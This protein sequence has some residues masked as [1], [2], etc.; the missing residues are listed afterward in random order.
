MI[1]YYN[2]HIGNIFKL[3]SLIFMGRESFNA[4]DVKI[5]DSYISG[6]DFIQ[7]RFSNL[8]FETKDALRP[9]VFK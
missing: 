3:G 1:Y 5:V 6:Y 2:L 4:N 9:V 8:A 7:D